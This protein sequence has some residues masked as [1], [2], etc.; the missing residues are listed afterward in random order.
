MGR[1]KWIPTAE[2]I[3]EVEKLAA[4]GMSY[5]Q[6]ADALHISIDTLLERRRDFSDFSGAIKKGRAALFAIAGG[7]L[8]DTM[9]KSQ[10]EELRLGAAQF[11]LTRRAGW[12]EKVDGSAIEVNING[13]PVSIDDRMRERDAQMDLLRW[14]T[15]QEKSVILD[16]YRLAQRRQRGEEPMVHAPALPTLGDDFEPLDESGDGFDPSANGK[17]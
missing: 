10:R 8:F 6:I 15:P 17:S 16:L 13:Q 2:H 3:R 7:I 14:L 4:R 12:S 9:T 11:V 5:Q 1:P